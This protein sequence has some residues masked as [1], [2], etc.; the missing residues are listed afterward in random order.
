MGI[1]KSV[2]GIF[3]GSQL[4]RD[5]FNTKDGHLKSFGEYIG[6]MKFTAEEMAEMDAEMAAGVRKFAIDTLSENT[7]RSKARRELAIFILQSF[8]LFL[9]LAGLVYPFNAEWSAFWLAIATKTRLDEL[10]GGVGLFFWG[11]HVVRNVM[12]KK[13]G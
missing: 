8:V 13:A 7:D 12:D 6:N 10:A 4:S 9:F 2:V 5:V 11:V 3:K 1:L